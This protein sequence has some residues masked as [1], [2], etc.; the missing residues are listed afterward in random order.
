M[1]EATNVQ[2][3]LKN[4]KESQTTHTKD[5]EKLVELE[6]LKVQYED[7]LMELN[8]ITEGLKE[9]NDALRED[10]EHWREKAD[11]YLNDNVA[12]HGVA[13]TLRIENGNLKAEVGTSNAFA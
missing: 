11:A 6:D 9:E 8:D 7:R 12:L 1:S 10:A 2:A 4:L 5:K 3:T 13:E